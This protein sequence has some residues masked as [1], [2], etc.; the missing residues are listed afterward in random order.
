MPLP[1]HRLDLWWVAAPP[2]R[3]VDARELLAV[4]VDQG[5]WQG[6]GTP[7]V[8]ADALIE[9]G[10]RQVRVVTEPAPRLVANRLGGFRVRCPETGVLVVRAFN[11]AIARWRQGGPR[12]LDRC[13]ACG[14]DHVLEDL[15]FEPP[16]AWG[17][18]ALKWIDAKRAVLTPEA[19]DA[20]ERA[21][22]QGVVV[23]VRPG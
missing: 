13:P 4:G 6:D 2:E 16:A 5:W 18:S 10:F 11:R 7:G 21:V 19:R 14:Q 3:A 20:L 23:A 17:S 8:R 12:R 9:G 22:G 1:H 15:T